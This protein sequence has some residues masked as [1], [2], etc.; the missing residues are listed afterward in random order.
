MS[1]SL[2]NTCMSDFAYVRQ[3]IL[4]GLRRCELC[5]FHCSPAYV[6][7]TVKTLE[8]CIN[9]Y[10]RCIFF[11]VLS[12]TFS[13]LRFIFSFSSSVFFS[14][15]PLLRFV[16]KFLFRVSPLALLQPFVL[17]HFEPFHSFFTVPTIF[18]LH[19]FIVR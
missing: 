5:Y 2:T 12:S 1:H 14:A 4:Y 11:S 15:F 6:K 10:F 18:F 13:R 9:V 19:S 8:A 3:I 16:L 7:E 17:L